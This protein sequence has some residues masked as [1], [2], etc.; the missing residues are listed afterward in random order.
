MAN[1]QQGQVGKVV[2]VMGAVVDIAFPTIRNFLPS[3]TQ[4]MSKMKKAL[5]R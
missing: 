1:E 2:Q 5:F 4:F 3:I